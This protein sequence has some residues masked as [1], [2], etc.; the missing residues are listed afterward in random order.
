[1]SD[2][3]R[4][5]DPG[6]QPE[7]TLLA[8][9]RIAVALLCMALAAPRFAWPVFG[10]AAVVPSGI[11]VAGAVAVL[12]ASHRRY[13]QTHRALTADRPILPTDAALHAAA[14]LVAVGFSKVFARG[15]LA[16]G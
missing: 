13:V 9:R 11:A 15:G 2:P 3:D 8:W 7:R 10:S 16:K 6:L 14:A 1:M 4:V 12:F 5:W